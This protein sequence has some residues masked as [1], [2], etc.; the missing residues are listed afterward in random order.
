MAKKIRANL[1][2]YPRGGRYPDAPL[3]FNS[4]TPRVEATP[5]E[6]AAFGLFQHI[7]YCQQHGRAN[8]KSRTFTPAPIYGVFRGD[9]LITWALGRG[10][11]RWAQRRAGN[12]WNNELRA[13][14]LGTF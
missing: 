8:P 12:C 14:Y 3:T 10:G 4:E 9:V 2:Q 5:E 13:Q 1:Y 11:R 6:R 7:A